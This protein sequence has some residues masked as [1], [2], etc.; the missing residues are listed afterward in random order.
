MGG[1]KWGK[2]RRRVRRAGDP[3]FAPQSRSRLSPAFLAFYLI[4][5]VAFIGYTLLAS[6]VSWLP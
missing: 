4:N 6:H 5:A 1:V 3:H 2:N